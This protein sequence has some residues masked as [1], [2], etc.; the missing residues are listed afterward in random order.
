MVRANT[1]MLSGGLLASIHHAWI[2]SGA[3]DHLVFKD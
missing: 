3:T 1:K 2:R